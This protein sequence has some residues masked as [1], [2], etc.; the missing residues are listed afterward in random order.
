MEKEGIP[1]KKAEGLPVGIEAWTNVLSLSEAELI[2]DQLEE[3]IG[4]NKCTDTS[5]QKAPFVHSPDISMLKGND[6]I[7]LS[8]HSFINKNCECGI[9]RL[10]SYIGSL[11]MKTLEEYANKYNIGFTQDEGFIA[12]KYGDSHQDGI[13]IDD[14]PYINRL[15]SWSLALNVEELIQYIKFDKLDYTLSTTSPTII[16]Y[17]SNFIYSYSKPNVDGLY[18]IQNY[19]NANPTQEL[20]DEALSQSNLISR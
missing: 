6:G 13:S 4:S 2:I 15:V 18:E 3:S 14:N 8:H 20:L 7:N 16:I 19:F 10:E 11:M 9:K 12:V 5:W 17:P 1:M